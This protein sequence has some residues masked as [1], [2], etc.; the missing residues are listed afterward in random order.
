MALRGEFGAEAVR[1]AHRS[2]ARRA[3]RTRG[4]SMLE[5]VAALAVFSFGAAILFDWMAQ[6]SQTLNRVAIAQ[7]RHAAQIRALDYLRTID[8]NAQPQGQQSLGSLELTWR[9]EPVTPMRPALALSGAA[10][11]YD[12]GS[13]KVTAQLA[14]SANLSGYSFEVELTQYALTRARDPLSLFR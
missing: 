3:A 8:L 4:F 11:A 6:T 13:S 12:V 2:P 9:S 14:G 7:E 5:T 1:Q 10:D